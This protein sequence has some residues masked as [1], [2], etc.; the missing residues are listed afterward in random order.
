MGFKKEEKKV[1]KPLNEEE[2]II[3]DEK[4]EEEIEEEVPLIDDDDAKNIIDAINKEKDEFLKV[5]K[6]WRIWGLVGTGVFLILMI[7]GFILCT[8]FIK[9]ENYKWV[10]G[11]GVGLI[12]VGFAISIALSKVQKSKVSAAATKYADY[13]YSKK[14]E[15]VFNIP[16]ISNVEASGKCD[17]KD[18]FIN[19]KFYKDIKTVRSRFGVKFTYN[20]K[21]CAI[22]ETAGCV[23]IKNRT[24][25]KFLG[26]FFVCPIKYEK[27]TTIL[28]Q[29]KGKELSQPVDYIDN[30][31][32][33]EGNDKFVIY[34]NDDE[35]D[36]VL[37][38]KVL[39]LLK[40]FKIKDPI[41][42]VILSIHE[43][44][45]SIGIDY[46]D[47]YMNAPID[48][49]LDLNRISKEKL[50]IEKLLAIIKEFN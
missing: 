43:N 34:S 7:A 32:L 28:F 41:I 17:N 18:S 45:L 19:A 29:L 36:Q 16:G 22:S 25:P 30:L 40:G 49:D 48:K 11:I 39:G 26:K 47:E 37:T 8:T 5:Q 1:V 50:D 4:V 10:S 33:K 23:L 38:S 9:D 13:Y 2:S 20:K 24:S 35:Y 46:I 3:Q 42:D 21:E 14:A 12:V 27:P 44:E 31:E 6:K 15:L